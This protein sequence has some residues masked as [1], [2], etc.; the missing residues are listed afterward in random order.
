[1]EDR[2]ER[3]PETE[4]QE[5]EGHGHISGHESGLVGAHDVGQSA[6]APGEIG[7]EDDDVEAHGHI[8]SHVGGSHVGSHDT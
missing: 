8:S 7:D 6:G 3:T 4:E 5:V 2:E 1:M